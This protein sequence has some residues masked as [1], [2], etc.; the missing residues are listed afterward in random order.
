MTKADTLAFTI[1]WIELFDKS[2]ITAAQKLPA[3]DAA[4]YYLGAYD[5]SGTNLWLNPLQTIDAGTTWP[6][7]NLAWK[8][9]DYNSANVPGSIGDA[10][11]FP[12]FDGPFKLTQ[13]KTIDTA[14]LFKLY[15]MKTAEYNAYEAL[16]TT[17]ETSR[18]AYNK[19][20][21]N[22]KAR[23]ADFFKSILE[24]PLTIPARPCPPTKPATWDWLNLDIKGSQ[25]TGAT[26]FTDQAAATVKAWL[27][28]G[29]THVPTTDFTIRSGN[30][31]VS[32]DVAKAETISE[33][34]HVFGRLGQG[35][36][37]LPANAAPFL[38]NTAVDTK[39][40]YMIISAF[41]NADGDTGLTADTKFIQISAKLSD[42][43]TTESL[44]PPAE[45][46]SPGALSS[47]LGGLALAGTGIIAAAT[48]AASLI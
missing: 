12:G 24:T 4:D 21:E 27:N 39:N 19:A 30:L 2:G 33:A 28:N 31:Q 14:V 11:Y 45:K 42:W 15:T 1:H 36:N 40:T 46:P 10:I 7:S 34:G 6:V 41:P 16:R 22:E 38:W 48:V 25:A 26:W 32:S 13:T 17:Y 44:G 8:Y 23:R 5:D 9:T 20:I 18:T 43:A 3:A 29:S 47:P 37:S 35:A